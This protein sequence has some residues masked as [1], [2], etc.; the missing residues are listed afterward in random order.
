MKT[1]CHD[2]NIL[3]TELPKEQRAGMPF[4]RALREMRYL[5]IRNRN[6]DINGIDK[7]AKTAAQDDGNLRDKVCSFTKEVCRLENAIVEQAG[8]N[9]KM[10]K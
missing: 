6:L 1:S 2:Y 9:E 3:S 5:I 8:R 10:K 4:D 7:S